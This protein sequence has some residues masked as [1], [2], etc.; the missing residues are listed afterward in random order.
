IGDP[1]FNGLFCSAAKGTWTA[2]DTISGCVFGDDSYSG[3]C[4]EGCDGGQNGIV[5]VKDNPTKYK[6]TADHYCAKDPI[7]GNNVCAPPDFSSSHCDV[8]GGTWNADKCETCDDSVKNQDERGVDCGGVCA[9]DDC[10]TNDVQDDG[11]LGVDCGGVCIACPFYGKGVCPSQERGS[12]FSSD[13]CPEEE[14]CAPDYFCRETA[15]P[16]VFGCAYAGEDMSACTAAGSDRWDYGGCLFSGDTLRSGIMDTCSS[17]DGGTRLGFV[18]DCVDGSYCVDPDDAG[19]LSFY[20]APPD[21]SRNHCEATGVGTWDS[22]MERCL[23]WCGNNICEGD[24]CNTCVEDCTFDDCCPDGTCQEAYG[25]DSLTCAGDC[26]GNA[27][28]EEGD[29]DNCYTDCTFEE[30]CPDG[31]CQPEEDLGTCPDDCPAECTIDVAM[32]TD[33]NNPDVTEIVGGFPIFILIIGNNICSDTIVTFEV[34]ETCAGA[35]IPPHPDITFNYDENSGAYFAVDAIDTDLLTINEEYFFVVK[36]TATDEVLI[37][38][39][40]LEN[41]YLKILESCWIDDPNACEDST[42]PTGD[43]ALNWDDPRG[44]PDA[45]CDGIADCVDDWIYSGYGDGNMG[46]FDET[47]AD[48]AEAWDCSNSPWSECQMIEGEYVATRMVRDCEMY[49]PNYCCVY[50]GSNCPPPPSRKACIV[51]EEFPVFTWFNMLL[52]VMMLASFYFYKIKKKF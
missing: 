38:S 11:E 18:F 52:V 23:G 34:W 10:C 20:C 16:E 45:D 46:Y 48:C 36:D 49:G 15:V 42:L 3:I 32:W 2:F 24:E 40:A 26:C 44:F 1:A 31:T 12:C 41:G 25:E 9:A 7:S 8:I 4:D 47:L 50:D 30:C 33:T 35:C 39:S 6:C 19:P 37:D 51:E 17:P 28:C 29:C 43:P 5:L 13:Q 22:D 14:Q 27:I 21:F